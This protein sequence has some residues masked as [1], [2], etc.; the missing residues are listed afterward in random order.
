[1]EAPPERRVVDVFAHDGQEVNQPVRE[2]EQARGEVWARRGQ[3]FDGGALEWRVVGDYGARSCAGVDEGECEWAPR[4]ARPLRE[5]FPVLYDSA[6]LDVH[7]ELDRHRLIRATSW[8]S[9][10]R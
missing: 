10:N 4:I 3:A 6:A 2:V 5:P 7:T 8:P 9:G 1:G